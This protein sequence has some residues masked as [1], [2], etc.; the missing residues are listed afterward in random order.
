MERED[1]VAVFGHPPISYLPRCIVGPSSVRLNSRIC[2]DRRTAWF[3]P[4]G[5]SAAQQ[6]TIMKREVHVSAQRSKMREGYKLFHEK[7]LQ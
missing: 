3:G 6:V 2:P 5:I 1:R 7:V 4:L